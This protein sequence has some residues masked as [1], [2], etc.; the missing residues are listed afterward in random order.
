MTLS[1]HILDLVTGQPA[2]GV[3]IAL[4]FAGAEQGNG[5]TDSD[6][7]CRNLLGDAALRAGAYRLVFSA[8]EYLRRVHPGNDAPF[9]DDIPVDF[10]ITDTGRS[11]HVPLLLSP[12]GYSTYRGS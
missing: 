9:F 10:T 12:F 4:L 2:A 11:Y 3:R 6:G 8:G 5:V 7:R 1:T